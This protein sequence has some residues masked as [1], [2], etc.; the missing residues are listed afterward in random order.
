MPV[1][2]DRLSAWLTAIALMGLPMSAIAAPVTSPPA[3]LPMISGEQAIE[4][5]AGAID[6]PQT[7]GGPLNLHTCATC[8]TE[9]YATDTQTVYLARGAR[10]SAI[11]WQALAHSA[12]HTPATVVLDART[13]VV[14]R[15]LIDLA[16][17][18]RRT[19]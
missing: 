14:T 19:P 1:H 4:T 16:A 12:A 9:R 10:L 6:L 15:V 2:R 8:P 11:E 18:A 13:H 3:R 7:V 17:P 5:E